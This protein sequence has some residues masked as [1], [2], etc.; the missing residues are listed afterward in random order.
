MPPKRQRTAEGDAERKRQHAE[1][2]RM[3]RANRSE[4]QRLE[5]RER[6]AENKRN[7]IAN[8]SAEERS[9]ERERRAEIE[10]NRVASLSEEQRS[11][12]RER[13]AEIERNRVANLSEEK[14]SIERERR[15]EIE[16]NRVASR[17][18]EQCSIERERHAEIERNRVA[19][20]SEEQRSLERVRHA[21][22]ERN[23]VASLSEEQRSVELQRNSKNKRHRA[24]NMA[25]PQ[26]IEQRRANVA[27]A[28]TS[29]AATRLRNLNQ[30]I[31][32][33]SINRFNEADIQQHTC[34]ELNVPCS[35]CGAKHFLK[36]RPQDKKFTQCCQ[37]GKNIRSINSALAFASMGANIA[38]G[39]IYHRTG[40]LHPT[41]GDQRKCAQLYILDPDE[42]CDQRMMIRENAHCNAEIM[43]ELSS[44]M[45][46]NNPFAKAFKMLYEVEK[47]CLAEATLNGVEPATVAMA[48]VQD[49]NSDQRRYNA[50]LVNE[51]AV[52]F[53]NADGEPPLERDILIHCRPNENDLNPKR[54]ERIN[55]LDPNLEPMVYPLLFPYGDQSWGIDL[56]LN[57]PPSLANMRQPFANPR[58]R[59][60]QMQYYG[61]R[62]S[63]RDELNP[64]LCAGKLTQQ[65]FVDAY[66]K[67]EANRLNFCRQNQGT[68]RAE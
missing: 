8:L 7:R 66:V 58:T 27:A 9:I 42:A 23:R 26:R 54:T 36:E 21:E 32:A 56:K 43:R 39:Q 40:S 22:I 6:N 41:N 67:T 17:S 52:L 65:Y 63:I 28:S 25:T 38:P 2:M 5:E 1:N 55:I 18:E 14:R 13:H 19:S 34:G 50:P 3:R 46:Q 30:T 48:I 53:Q 59:I 12:E 10:R 31:H 35:F 24:A 20:L 68:L 57:R 11:L 16:R 47:E 4:E 29:R 61:Y 45:A 33:A 64:F 49:R 15:A 51:V 60:T 37:K 62:L 44:F